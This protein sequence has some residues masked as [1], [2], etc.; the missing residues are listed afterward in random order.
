MDGLWQDLRYASRQLRRSPGFTL[1]ALF[2][3]ALGI[4]INTAA[5]TA[6]KAMI[7]RPLDARDPGRMVDLSLQRQSGAADT[8]FS[9]PDYEAYRD[10]LHSFAGVI[11]T[12]PEEVLT[13]SAAGGS[14]SQ[15][16]A[17]SSSLLESLGM[18][19]AMPVAR[20]AEMATALPVSGNYFSALGI[21]ALRGRTFDAMTSEEL[22]ASPSVLI[23][24]NYWRRRFNGDPSILGRVVRLNGAAF[25]IIGIT[26]HGFVGTSFAEPAFW[27]PLR[28]EP[29]LYPG[30][31][32]WLSNR[33]DQRCWLFGRLAAGA[34]M[35][36]AQAEMTL[37][38]DRLRRLHHPDSD[39]SK[40]V[41]ALLRPGSPFPNRLPHA[42]QFT[43]LLILL[44]VG[45]VLVIACANVASLQLA[46]AAARQ[47][48]LSI[49]LSLGATRRRLIRQLLTES[50]LL[51]LLAGGAA[52]LMTSALLKL[53]AAVAA[54]AL[55]VEIGSIVVNVTPDLGIFAYV[56]ALSLFA[57]VLFGLAPALESSRF[58]VSSALKANSGTSPA[59]GR[60]IRN[61]LIAAQVAFSLMLMISGSL[62]IRSAFNA[63]RKETGFA[64]NRVV[65]LYLKFPAGAKYPAE[66]R[67][68][69]VRALSA[70]LAALPGVAEITSGRAPNGDGLRGVAVSLNGAGPSAHNTQAWLY[71]TYVQPNY[72]ETLGIPVLSGH[73]F[74]AQAGRT[75]FSVIV[76]E[77]AARRLWPA[78]NPIGRTLRMSTGEPSRS[79]DQ[80]LPDGPTY[81][82]IGV[83]RDTRAMTLDGKDA[84]QI[85]V[86]LPADRVDNNSL[87][88]RTRSDPALL[89]NALGPVVDAVD[90]NVLSSAV[91]LEA[92][93]RQTPVFWS[94]ALAALIAST[95][96]LLGLVLACMGIYGTV[97]Y[98]VVL[99]TREVGIRMALGAKRGDV[100]ALMLKESAR[101][102]VAGLAV[103]ACL[104]VGS[105]YLM[106]GVLYG[107]G[108]V[109]A[110]SFG[111]VSLLFF[112]I[113]LAAAY[114]PSRRAMRVEPLA[115]LRYE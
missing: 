62:L 83:A 112:G 58:A 70:R 77:S 80:I 82:V 18:A 4:G 15:L 39:Q 47:N 98:I 7:L 3:L 48:E 25:T 86:P 73:G 19:P 1:A 10:H 84:E 113:A 105:S 29:L 50:V 71:Y 109:D 114:V 101:P 68:A 36:Q 16:G 104:A 57:G 81:Q 11:A 31:A 75:E 65:C 46:R 23:S 111:G 78:R 14:R 26:P 69:I 67:T 115:A 92:M 2:A 56:F 110:V 52:L 85:Y 94:S 89:V 88:I 64:A 99:R 43:I 38:A 44:A 76:S 42:L 106:R 74:A 6:Y 59:R 24:E 5:F 54:K 8:Y 49:R 28:Q 33:E 40:P 79:P 51:G 17:T 96:G 20:D 41:T 108:P 30:T 27:L 60:R 22:A 35:G 91:T 93:L 97:S 9:Y 13:L 100:L 21:R 107:L 103:G 32:N 12:G 95:V 34:G 45:L 102:V 87:L 63:L 66:R 72:L 37:L 61:S 90:P 53:L 55:P